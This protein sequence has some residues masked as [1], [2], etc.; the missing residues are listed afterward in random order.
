MAQDLVTRFSPSILKRSLL[1][2]VGASGVFILARTALVMPAPAPLYAL[3]LGGLTF[4]GLSLA[5][6]RAKALAEQLAER[7][8]L[9][10]GDVNKLTRFVDE[11]R[12]QVEKMRALR[13]QLDEQIQP[14]VDEIIEW[15]ER[16]IE[17]V[18][19][20]P[21]DIARSTRFEVYLQ[22]AVEITEKV[23]NLKN[24]DRAGASSG[25][26]E[27][28]EKSHVVLRDIRDVFCKQY[29]RNLENDI[30]DVDVDLDVLSKTLKREGL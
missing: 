21:T 27:V 25:V 3:L 17:G 4:V 13:D 16:I 2:G 1:A 9:S 18:I 12:A 24:S 30:L 26:H 29:E 8:Q 19:D 20:D 28:L 7:E 6:P 14:V 5:L 23:V 11:N 10:G 15:A 22:K